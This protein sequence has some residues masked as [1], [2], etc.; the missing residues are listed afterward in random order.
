MERDAVCGEEVGRRDRVKEE[1][2]KWKKYDR[3]V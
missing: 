2:K 1:R 3:D